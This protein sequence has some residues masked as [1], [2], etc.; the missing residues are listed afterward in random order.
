MDEGSDAART[1]S[2]PGRPGVGEP[3]PRGSADDGHRVALLGRDARRAGG[4]GRDAAVGVL[5]VP[6]DVTDPSEGRR[7]PAVERE[8]GPVEMLVVQRRQRGPR[9]LAETTDELWAQMIEI[10]L[11]APFRCIRRAVPD[12][13]RVGWGRIVVSPRSPPS[14]GSAGRGVLREQA[15]RPRARASRR[16]R[17]R[18]YRRDGNAVCPGYVDT[19][20]TD[21]TLDAM[22]R[23]LE[24]PVDEAR[25][26]LARRQ[27]IGRL[28]TADEVASAVL[29]CVDNGAINGQGINVDGGAVQS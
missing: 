24:I 27:P 14:G 16:G 29:A 12:M 26:I 9:Q 17:G 7:S 20:M 18:A 6:A 5:V 15:R 23:R 3:S 4:G 2:S 1:A 25:S 19:P 22:S 28:V 21:Q 13:V 10:N 11:T 8:W